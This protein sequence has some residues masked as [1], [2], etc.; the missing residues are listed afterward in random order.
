MVRVRAESELVGMSPALSRPLC[1]YPLDLRPSTLP[2]THYLMQHLRDFLHLVTRR[3]KFVAHVSHRLG[4]HL[5]LMS[6]G[7]EH[8][9]QDV[10]RGQSEV[11]L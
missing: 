10:L 5:P 4:M 6:L 7:C 9:E 8:H 3:S 11:F 1:P 2:L